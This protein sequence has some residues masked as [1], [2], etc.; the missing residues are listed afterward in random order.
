MKADEPDTSPAA[1]SA[2]ENQEPGLEIG[3]HTVD[4]RPRSQ[5]M[6][7]IYTY[8]TRPARF[9][10]PVTPTNNLTNA[11]PAKEQV[12]EVSSDAA[13]LS[14]SAEQVTSTPPSP[15]ASKKSPVPPTMLLA[16]LATA[17]LF[18]LLGSLLRSLLGEHQDYYT[19]LPA[20]AISTEPEWQEMTRVLELKVFR[21]HLVV[22]FLRGRTA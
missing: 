13:D 15:I 18:F 20:G 19:V 21:W 11:S 12:R 16:M 17:V 7:S 2:I 22:A 10:W 1:P 9:S 14:N 8:L 3:A 5:R 6:N 4:A